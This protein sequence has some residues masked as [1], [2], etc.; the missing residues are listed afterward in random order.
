[1]PQ[2][3]VKLQFG[4]NENMNSHYN[5]ELDTQSNTPLLYSFQKDINTYRFRKATFQD[6]WEINF[7]L[8]SLGS[9]IDMLQQILYVNKSEEEI[10]RNYGKCQK[11]DAVYPQLIKTINDLEDFVNNKIISNISKESPYNY[12]NMLRQ[13]V[14]II[15]K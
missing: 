14:F 1:V 10:K 12:P 15:L 4:F 11:F 7:L 2:S 3:G 5:Q 6:I 13:K 8:A 9:F